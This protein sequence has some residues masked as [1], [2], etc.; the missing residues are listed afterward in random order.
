MQE[1]ILRLFNAIQAEGYTASFYDDK[2]SYSEIQSY[3]DSKTILERTIRNGYILDPTIQP[4]EKLLDIIESVVG[5]SGE[6]ANAV[7]HK[8]WKVVRDSPMELLV[9]QQIVHYLTTYTFESLGIY[10]EDAVYIPSEILELPQIRDNLPLVLVKA[11]TAQEILD[12]IIDLGSDIALAQETLDDIMTIIRANAYNSDF[13]EKITNRE[14]KALLN[15]FYEIVP[16]EPVEF[17]RH[18][19]SKLTNESLLIKNDY[20]IS[21]IKEANGKFLDILLVD[22]PDNLASIFFRFKPLFL[23]LKTISKNK[24]FFNRLR[25]QAEKLH[26]PM[27]EDYLNNITSQIKQ[28]T[29][30]LST[31]EQKLEKASIFRKIRLAYALKFRDNPGNSIVYRIRNGRGWATEFDWPTDLDTGPAQG[32][33]LASIVNDVRKNVEGKIIHIPENVYYTLP[34]TEK[35]FTGHFPTGSYVSVPQDLIVGIHWTNTDKRVDLDLSVIGLS[36]KIGWDASYRSKHQGVFF[37]GDMTH[38]SQ[39]NGATELFY[40]K[41]AAQLPKI[42]MVNYYNFERGDEVRTKI[43]VASEQPENFGMNY[44]VDINNI[45]ASA[46]I[47]VSKKQ[48]VLGLITSIDSENRVYFANVSVGNSIT[49]SGNEQATQTRNYL[50]NS[51]T[52]SLGLRWVLK[53]AG[54]IVVSEKPD[55]EYVELSPE[56]LDKSAILELI[57]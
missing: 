15:D 46:N 4:N 39:E 17:L 57:K 13:V 24:T 30:D 44:M 32:I 31:L 1:A 23:A 28:G 48:N 34:A 20:L 12:K 35:Q 36:G 40:F 29:L 21:K 3:L 25:K 56:A 8:S 26:K 10:D 19:I 49:A 51:L 5:I 54:A 14:L 6:K 41:Q 33:V 52:N 45:I 43:L 11:I 42:M 7:F 55:G 47:N 38:A 2:Q 53:Q 16:T 9:V 50:I 37:S 22:A 27:P 18:L